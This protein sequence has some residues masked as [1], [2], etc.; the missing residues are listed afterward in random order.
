MILNDRSTSEGTSERMHIIQSPPMVCTRARTMF[1]AL[2]K[3]TW[4]TAWWV[5]Y[6]A[7]SLRLPRRI[8]L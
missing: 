2:T 5:G 7:P 4:Y 3:R 1:L 6:Q 8:V